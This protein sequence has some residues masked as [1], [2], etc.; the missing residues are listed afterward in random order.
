MFIPL[1][2]A[3]FSLDVSGIAGFFGGEES[4]AAMSSVHLIWGRRFFGWYNSPG[5]YFV[6]KKYGTL[7]HRRLWKGLFPGETVDPETMLGLDG[8]IGPQ[9]IGTQSGTTMLTTGHLAYLLT[10]HCKNQEDNAEPLPGQSA[11]G[12][13]TKPPIKLTILDLDSTIESFLDPQSSERLPV[14]SLTKTGMFL[15]S[16]TMSVSIGA[17]IVAAALWHDW[18]CFAAIVVGI[19]CNGVSCLVLGS[20]HLKLAASAPSA[21][22]PS[23][24]GIFWY[25]QQAV[26]VKGTEKTI[27]ILTRGKFRL[28]YPQDR[29]YNYIGAVAFALTV[30]VLAQ[31]FL[32]PQAT[33]A[34][35]ILFLFTFAVSWA[36]NSYLAST[37]REQLQ[38]DLLLNMLGHPNFINPGPLPTRAAA[39]V[40]SAYYLQPYN[41]Q[42]YINQLLPNDTPVWTPCKEHIATCVQRMSDP[43]DEPTSTE[44]LIKHEQKLTAKQKNLR[45]DI[46]SS[47]HAGYTWHLGNM[48]TSATTPLKSPDGNE[49]SFSEQYVTSVNLTHWQA[50]PRLFASNPSDDPSS[51]ESYS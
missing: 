32:L 19:L 34:G 15:M 24:D 8:R 25:G 2:H 20:G 31:L 44:T 18:P 17:A 28:L 48:S 47:A 13:P 14:K 35:Q 29:D 41:V 39:V 11:S 1:Q 30:Q 33:L 37:D 16:A 51:V 27:A 6:A 4:F 9:Y 43:I 45:N 49:K 3:K 12:A 42:S 46:L 10:Q 22:S 26:L 21:N 38:V 40:A 50:R 7:C 5:S 36:Y 23:G